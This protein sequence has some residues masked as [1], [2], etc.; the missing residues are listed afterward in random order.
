[1]KCK[2][3]GHERVRISEWNNHLK[4]NLTAERGDAKRMLKEAKDFYEIAKARLN[5][6]ERE[7]L[8]R[9]DREAKVKL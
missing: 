3:C 7:Y 4:E 1:M 8:D 6:A 2:N 5:I 9:E